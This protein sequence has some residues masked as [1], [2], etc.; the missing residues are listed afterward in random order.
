MI[1]IFKKQYKGKVMKKI[2]YIIFLIILVFLSCHLT[3]GDNN[4]T[5][6]EPYISTINS[7]D[8]LNLENS[9]FYKSGNV[10]YDSVPISDD[11]IIVETESEELYFYKDGVSDNSDI[12]TDE[13]NSKYISNLLYDNNLNREIFLQ[14]TTTTTGCDIVKDSE[15]VNTYTITNN[16]KRWAAIE[17]VNSS[18]LT[19]NF[20]PPRGNLI[21]FD[22]A[23]ILSLSSPFSILEKS[24]YSFIPSGEEIK[25]YGSTFKAMPI[26]KLDFQHNSSGS[27]HYNYYAELADSIDSNISI[28]NYLTVREYL[29]SILLI[30]DSLDVIPGLDLDKTFSDEIIQ[31]LIQIFDVFHKNIKGNESIDEAVLNSVNT[32]LNEISGII[33]DEI[34]ENFR[35]VNSTYNSRSITITTLYKILQGAI[36]VI[37]ALDWGVIGLYDSITYSPYETITLYN[38]NFPIADAGNDSVV[39][40]GS[41]VTLNGSGSY[42]DETNSNDLQYNWLLVKKPIDSTVDIDIENSYYMTFFPDV[43]GKYEFKIEVTDEGGLVSFD[44]VIVTSDDTPTANAGIDKEVYIGSPLTLD[45]G[46]SSDT[47]TS[48]ENLLYNW[49]ITTNIPFGSSPDLSGGDSSNPS[50]ST[51]IHGDYEIQLEVTDDNGNSD[52]DSIIIHVKEI[53]VLTGELYAPQEGSSFDIGRDITFMWGIDNDEAVTYSYKFSDSDLWSDWEAITK[54][55]RSFSSY[56]TFYINVKVKDSN[57]NIFTIVENPILIENKSISIDEED[58]TPE[59]SNSGEGKN[60]TIKV[61][62]YY[63]HGYA[64]V[65]L[66]KNDNDYVYIWVE[67]KG[68]IYDSKGKTKSDS[69]SFSYDAKGSYTII[70]KLADDRSVVYEETVSLGY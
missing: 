20:L 35:T 60:I 16:L 57:G 54:T 23:K 53:D 58:T 64:Y 56:G 50:F 40:T 34:I 36:A 10:Y 32:N 14:T 66:N 1:H 48:T 69:W 67:H 45:G 68:N 30:I 38:N 12:L 49:T 15:N 27:L 52:V 43:S 29:D 63:E 24:E 25:I 28:I 26:F 19:A 39:E 55:N 65:K 47:E 22:F 37:N 44:N 46:A 51:D 42:D 41:S 62:D 7:V 9:I 18:E 3:D 31:T 33:I 17:F 21:D 70:V 11:A 8:Y 4:S 2:K 59:D 13:N 5:D 6:N 61:T